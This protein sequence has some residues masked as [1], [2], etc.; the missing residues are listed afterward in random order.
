MPDQGRDQVFISYSHEDQRWLE[1]LQTTLAPL[2]RQGTLNVWV[3]T[4]IQTGAKWRREIETA[5]ASTR[6]A[7]LLVSQHFLASDFIIEHEL[8][9]LLKAAEED[10]AII[11]WVAVSASL[12]EGTEI[13]EYQ[14][15]NDPTK[16]LDSLRGPQLNK[17]LVSI[18]RKIIAAANAVTSGARD[19]LPATARTGGPNL[20]RLVPRMCDRTRQESDFNNFFRTMQRLRPGFPQVYFIHGEER[21]CHDSLVER[22]AH[23]RIKQFAE[24]T[25]GEQRGVVALKRLSW[26]YQGEPA[27]LQQELTRVL[28][29]QFDYPYMG[30]D[31]SPSAFSSLASRLLSSVIIVQHSIHAAN[32]SAAT[33]ALIKWYLSFW[34]QVG[35]VAAGPQFI[36]FLSVAYPRSSSDR[37]WKRW[38]QGGSRFDK[39]AIE[40]DL[41]EIVAGATDN[42][43]SLLLTEL[44]PVGQNEVKD[45]FSIHNIHTEKIRYDLLN[46]MF[47]TDSGEISTARSMAD[48]EHDLE[49][50]FDSI[51]KESLR[52]RGYL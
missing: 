25:W 23:T 15:A 47:L 41:R 21:E 34:A 35:K 14:A 7:V 26:V 36:I 3:D 30:D 50:I 38:T 12:Y 6:V 27:E 9:P 8:P 49:G 48:I 22:L 28:V 19:G 10:G 17:E 11:I 32:W 24:R 16:P 45:W 2:V 44:L 18:A 43:P 31:L 37:W 42:C 1:K 4:K 46:K 51:Q 29:E 52:V 20:G 5:L 33:R 13:A 39:K 40:K